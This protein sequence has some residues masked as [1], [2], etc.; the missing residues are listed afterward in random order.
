MTKMTTTQR[1]EFRV[2]LLQRSKK[3]NLWCSYQG[4]V[5]CVFERYGRFSWS[6]ADTK[7]VRYS[8]KLYASEWDAAG[9]L[10]KVIRLIDEKV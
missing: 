3:G 1:D 5:V 2:D 6:I 4:L 10:A 7:G 9:A 8:R